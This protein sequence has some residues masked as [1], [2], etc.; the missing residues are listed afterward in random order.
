MVTVPAAL[1]VTLPFRSTAATGPELVVLDSDVAVHRVRLVGH[2]VGGFDEYHRARRA[3]ERV[4]PDQDVA[5][6]AGLVPPAGVGRDEDAGHLI[7]EDPTLAE[8]ERVVRAIVR[9][10][11]DRAAE[12]MTEHLTLSLQRRL[13][14]ENGA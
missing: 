1:A 7:A 13:R 14:Q 10:E 5:D 8:H 11:A 9:G 3:Q 6:G 4:V 12:A 2:L